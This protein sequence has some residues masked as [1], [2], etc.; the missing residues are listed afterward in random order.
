MY[1]T[2]TIVTGTE[3]AR[4]QFDPLL[5]DFLSVHSS[6]L[7][8]DIELLP[9]ILSAS[10]PASP[11]DAQAEQDNITPPS[12]SSS[13]TNHWHINHHR[14]IVIVRDATQLALALIH[15]DAPAEREK[16]QP[17]RQ[18]VSP[19]KPEVLVAGCV[20]DA[21]DRAAIRLLALR[22][23]NCGVCLRGEPVKPEE[24]GLFRGCDDDE[25]EPHYINEELDDADTDA[26]INGFTHSVTDDEF[27][28][29][30]QPRR[31]DFGDTDATKSKDEDD[32][33]RV[34]DIFNAYL[35]HWSLLRHRV[36]NV[37]AATQLDSDQQ[38]QAG[39]D[40][41]DDGIQQEDYVEPE[42]EWDEKLVWGDA[43]WAAGPHDDL[44][45]P[46]NWDSVDKIRAVVDA[47]SIGQFDSDV[48]R[49]V[50][51]LLE[52]ARKDAQPAPSLEEEEKDRMS[53][54]NKD[55]KES[56]SD[57]LDGHAA[58]LDEMDRKPL[59]CPQSS[60]DALKQKKKERKNHAD[61][62]VS[63]EFFQRL[64]SSPLKSSRL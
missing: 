8:V 20:S 30:F 37:E 49:R 56:A 60:E 10:P 63:S 38:P 36:T 1:L 26:E 64:L 34:R 18:P 43:V 35:T 62:P 44:I 51:S 52:Q 15:I 54:V 50:E 13:S 57:W 53:E 3:D 41:E 40:E 32:G 22:H 31:L 55:K 28:A 7:I 47:T 39:T 29:Q 17:D 58:W 19:R 4:R 24:S 12:T 59:K 16:E 33:G 14:Y 42:T 25:E 48:E 45:I 46:P 23:S 2:A 5:S 6:T 61:I 27:N 9:S 11:S 21:L